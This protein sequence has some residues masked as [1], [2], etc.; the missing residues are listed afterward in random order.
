MRALVAAIVRGPLVST[1]LAWYR[2]LRQKPSRRQGDANARQTEGMRASTGKGSLSPFCPGRSPGQFW[3]RPLDLGPAWLGS[4]LGADDKV[5][6]EWQLV[7]LSAKR[8]AN[9]TFPSIP[10]HRGSHLLGNRHAKPWGLV[11][12][13]CQR[14]QNQHAICGAR[15]L[16][17]NLTELASVENSLGFAERCGGFWHGRQ[18]NTCDKQTPGG[19]RAQKARSP[20]GELGLSCSNLRISSCD[21]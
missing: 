3:Y 5:K 8:F 6:T 2:R 13:G 7:L 14:H 9:Q 21:S 18:V 19:N 12:L 15:P 1:Q 11:L 20:R 17:Q 10:G 16:S 4:L